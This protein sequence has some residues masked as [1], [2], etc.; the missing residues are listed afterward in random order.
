[1][2]FQPMSFK[3]DQWLEVS[4]PD[5]YN[6]LTEPPGNVPLTR[7]YAIKTLYFCCFGRL[8]NVALL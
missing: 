8:Y 2:S 6:I 5:V 1:M 7:F 4:Y 3:M